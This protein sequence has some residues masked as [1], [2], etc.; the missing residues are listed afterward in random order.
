M[1]FLY[2]KPYL[3]YF[4]DTTLTYMTF[5]GFNENVTIPVSWISAEPHV[6]KE[7]ML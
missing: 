3:F 5:L 6:S 7:K 2:G 1:H 4:F